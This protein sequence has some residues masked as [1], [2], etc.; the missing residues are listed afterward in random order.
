MTNPHSIHIVRRFGPVGGMENY[1]FQLVRCLS[2]LGLAVTVVCETNE[3]SKA[4]AVEWGKNIHVVELG[5]RFRKPR[6]LAQLGFSYRVSRYFAMNPPS[7]DIVIHSHE[8][9]A[10]HHV[11]TFHGPPFLCRKRR[12][13]DC[14]SPRIHAWTYLERREVESAQVQAVLPNSP[15]IADEL[16][17]LYPATS[18]MMQ[19]PAYPGVDDAF[20][21][22]RRASD[23]RLVVGFQGREWKRKGLDIA[24]HIVASLRDL[25]PNIHFL[26]AGCDAKEIQP[27]FA[28]WP[29]NSYTIMGWVDEPEHFL[30]KID[31]LLHPARSEPFGMVIAEANA[32]GIP[33]IVSEHCGAAALITEKQGVVCALS[34]QEPDIASW[35]AACYQC[36]TNNMVVERLPLTWDALAQQHISLYQKIISDQ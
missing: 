34:R 25:L 19:A 20:S 30:S 33:V 5:N 10:V 16:L 35:V 36:L 18:L 27:L 23:E 7:S 3:S 2:E 11:T 6:W 22:I 17:R 21:L 4:S 14:L 8:R 28:R 24:C 31:V 26:V 15:M 13:L 32:A 1:V 12:V 9:T 29:E